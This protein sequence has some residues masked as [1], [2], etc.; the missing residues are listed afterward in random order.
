MWGAA[1]T[2]TITAGKDGETTL[3][4]TDHYTLT[5]SDTYTYMEPGTYANAI[6]IDGKGNYTGT[7]S[8]NFT[9]SLTI[10]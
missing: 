3:N 8:A 9:A 1:Q 10:G 5:V 6:T 2:P 7:K 4:T